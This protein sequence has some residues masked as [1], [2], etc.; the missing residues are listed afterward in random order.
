MPRKRK[1]DIADYGFNE[2]TWAALPPERKRHFCDKATYQRQKEHRQKY[3]R[4]H[5]RKMKYDK[6]S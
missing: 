3:A 6:T 5:K 2:I 1:F 4:E